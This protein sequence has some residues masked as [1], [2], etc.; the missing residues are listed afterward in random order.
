MK[1]EE[2]NREMTSEVSEKTRLLDVKKGSFDDV[3]TDFKGR[4]L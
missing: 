2:M 1:K 4:P 3:T